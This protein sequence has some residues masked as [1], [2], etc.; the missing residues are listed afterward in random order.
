MG[1]PI[2]GQRATEDQPCR[3]GDCQVG[4]HCTAE[5]SGLEGGMCKP[6]APVGARCEAPYH[7][8]SSI[9]AGPAGEAHCQGYESCS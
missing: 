4:L 9:C 5:I 3:P 6:P 7:C 8:Q 1:E 2:C